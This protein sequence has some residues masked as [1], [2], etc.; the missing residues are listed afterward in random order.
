MEMLL[1]LRHYVS[2]VSPGLPS[3]CRYLHSVASICAHVDCQR[4]AAQLKVKE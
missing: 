3:S 4:Q 2:M 1:S